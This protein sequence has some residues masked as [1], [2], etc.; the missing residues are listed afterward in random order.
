MKELTNNQ[1]E[2]DNYIKDFN[3]KNNKHLQMRK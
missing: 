3:R 2:K 1:N